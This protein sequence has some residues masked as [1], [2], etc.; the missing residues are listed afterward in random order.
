M[1]MATTQPTNTL[2]LAACSIA[3]SLIVLGL[4]YLAFALTGS[5]ALYSDALESI[6]NVVT[7]IAAFFAIRVSLRP[8]DASHPYGH[9][10]AEYFS[11]ALE[12]VLILIA[13][14]AILREAYGAFLDPHPIQAPTSGL[15]I[16]SVATVVN[17][18]WSWLLIRKGR[19]RR[20]PALVADGRH[21][22]TD[23][24]TSGG[25]IVGV[26][27]VA[28]TGWAQLDPAIAG[29]V[30]LHILSAGWGIVKESLGGLMDTALPKEDLE[31]VKTTIDAN[32]AGALEV[33]D[34]RSRHAGRTT[35]IDFHLVVDGAMTVDTSHAIC[36]RIEAALKASYP[37]SIISIHVEP[38]AKR[39]YGAMEIA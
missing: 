29:L 39:K 5:I 17:A 22:L 31:A 6:I 37:D 38:T 11:A 28:L 26:V 10:K 1:T 3:V 15:A 16:S 8:A 18:G 35:F 12:G 32:M 27:V 14:L 24:Y 23:V 9:S 21:L 4:K 33:H 36:D 2:A 25:V 13:S 20:S 34:L 30:A 7:A 19:E